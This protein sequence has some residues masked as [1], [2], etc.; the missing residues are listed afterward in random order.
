MR[1]CA[2]ALVASRSL[3]LPQP[4]A[5]AFNI[6]IAAEYWVQFAHIASPTYAR[7]PQLF[8]HSIRSEQLW[9]SSQLKSWLK[10]A[11]RDRCFDILHTPQYTMLER[12]QSISFILNNQQTLQP[13]FAF[14]PATRCQLSHSLEW[15]TSTGFVEG[16]NSFTILSFRSD[17]NSR[18]GSFARAPA[19]STPDSLERLER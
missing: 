19:V 13:L 6:D 5:A 2:F 17:F 4:I 18:P 8:L 10:M 15:L 9:S 3:N 11:A 16:K 12:V 14:Y 1:I 7:E